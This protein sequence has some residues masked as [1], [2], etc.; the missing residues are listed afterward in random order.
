MQKLMETTINEKKAGALD[1]LK[2]AMEKQSLFCNDLNGFAPKA[3]KRTGSRLVEKGLVSIDNLK[4][5]L[6]R[7]RMFGGK[8]GANLVAL[9]LMAESELADFFRFFPVVPKTMEETHLEPSFIA[10]LILKHALL[11]KSFSLPQP[12]VRDN[13]PFCTGLRE[14]ARPPSP[15]PLEDP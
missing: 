10:E 4:L 11:L 12:I 8:I 7:Q 1:S 5:A 2:R 6:E 14:T 15:R 9:G 13:P 3:P